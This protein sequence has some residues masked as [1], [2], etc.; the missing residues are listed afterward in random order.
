MIAKYIPYR[1]ILVCTLNHGSNQVFLIDKLVDI[2][3]SCRHNDGMIFLPADFTR[4]N[5]GSY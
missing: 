2:K 1:Y 3:K 4:A 5:A